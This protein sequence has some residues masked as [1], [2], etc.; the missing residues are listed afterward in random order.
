[1][2]AERPALSRFAF[3]WPRARRSRAA[4][5]LGCSAVNANFADRLAA[6]VVERSSQVVLG[7]DP[8]PAN[9]LP[10]AVEE[11]S[12]DLVSDG[13]QA[14][15]LAARAVAIHCRELIAAAAPACV[16]VKPQ[17]ACFERLGAP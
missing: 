5:A 17:L 6:A 2:A 8:D 12:R 3:R 4:A 10:G 16:A 15:E 1:R 11:A 13:R 9:L 7:L 14:A